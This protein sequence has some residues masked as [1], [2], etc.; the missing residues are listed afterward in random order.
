MTLLIIS[1][2]SENWKN[3]KYLKYLNQKAFNCLNYQEKKFLEPPLSKYFNKDGE[4]TSQIIGTTE[5][6]LKRNRFIFSNKV[7]FKRI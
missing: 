3:F 2:L 7:C 6:F 1:F 4:I 5:N